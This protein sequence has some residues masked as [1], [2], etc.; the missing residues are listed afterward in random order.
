MLAVL[1]FWQS[2]G[3][4]RLAG[5]E[6]FR[7]R[8][9]LPLTLPAGLALA[10]LAWALWG[11][12][13]GVEA[14]R[15]LTFG[16]GAILAVFLLPLSQILF[17]GT[18]DY[19]RPAD[20]IV[21]LGAR[22]Y[23]DGRCSDALADRVR[24]AAE[25][26]HENCKGRG[27][28]AVWVVMSGGPGDGAVHE[29][30]AMRNLAAGLGVPVERILLDRNGLNTEATARNVTALAAERRFTRVLAVS[31]AY[32]QPRIKLA[33]QRAGLNV[34]TVPAR[35]TYWLSSMPRL[36]LRETGALW[37]YYL[38]PLGGAAEM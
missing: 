1:A 29:T 15:P 12:R 6:G 4:Y 33:F 25:L 22:A 17:F 8:I 5:A 18:S 32:H 2:V 34:Y 21:V 16:A 20:A 7:P 36:I 28:R 23:A 37:A 3:F 30:E 9:P 38:R 10:G 27:D 13:W 24:T 26:Y 35:E 31:H 19:R 14:W 11:G